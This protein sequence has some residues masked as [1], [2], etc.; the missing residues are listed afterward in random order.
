MKSISKCLV[1]A[2]VLLAVTAYAGAA[3]LQAP[4]APAQEQRTFQGALVKIDTSAS[5]LT[6][7]DSNKKEW[8]FS[9][10]DKTEVVGPEKTIQ[11]L[12]GKSGT[13][14]TIRYTVE[15]GANLASRIEITSE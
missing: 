2:M 3:G 14:L 12:A 13:K 7:T 10:T 1:A 4:Q 8:T 5:T 11:G 15:R 6:A 9:Y